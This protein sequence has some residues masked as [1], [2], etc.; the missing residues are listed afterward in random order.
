MKRILA[1]ILAMAMLT[2]CSSNEPSSSQSSSSETS[3]SSSSSSSQSTSSSEAV[4]SGNTLHEGTKLKNAEQAGVMAAGETLDTKDTDSSTTIPTQMIIYPSAWPTEAFGEHLPEYTGE[5]WLFLT[6][7][8]SEK[9]DDMAN[10]VMASVSIYG[11]QEADLAAYIDQLIAMGYTEQEISPEEK[12][13]P[14]VTERQFVKGKNFAWID[15]SVDPDWGA[16]V[17]ISIALG[18]RGK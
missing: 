4:S 1:M 2:A 14:G 7:Y 15:M 6:L 10:A 5:G 13:I 11:Y 18:E 12:P 8:S 17:D 3:S 16:N 9:Q